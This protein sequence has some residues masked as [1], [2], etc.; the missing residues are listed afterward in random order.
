MYG[1]HE[2]VM[3]LWRLFVILSAVIWMPFFFLFWIMPHMISFM[4]AVGVDYVMDWDGWLENQVDNFFFNY[5]PL[6]TYRR[7]R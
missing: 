3:I 4:I 6:A 5:D 2:A 1:G 7:S